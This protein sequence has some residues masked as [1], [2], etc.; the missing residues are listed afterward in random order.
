MKV[1]IVDDGHY[2]V[3]YLKHLLDWKI[4][5]VDLVMTTTNPI[6][7]KEILRQSA[8]DILITDIRMPEVS[9]IDLLEYV[10]AMRLKAKVIFLSGYSDFEY[11]QKAIRLGAFDYL[12]K[13]VDKEDM[14]KVVRSVIKTIK[15]SRTETSAFWD[16]ANGLSY[17]VSAISGNDSLAP[18]HT[19]Q[20]N[21]EQERMCF[22]KCTLIDEE[23]ATNLKDKLKDLDALIWL[24]P[25]LAF[26]VASESTAERIKDAFSAILLSEPFQLHKKQLVRQIFYLF[27]YNEEVKPADF[28]ILQNAEEFSNLE[29]R[30]WESAR[31]K[32][33]KRFP[34]LI[35]RKHKII[36]LL[37]VAYYLYF[38]TD[39][40]PTKQFLDWLIKRIENPVE[41]YES[42]VFT[43]SRLSQG[44]ELPIEDIV[45]TIRTYISGHLDEALSL[46]EL[47]QIVHLHP[48]YL[49]KFYKQTTGENLSAHITLKRMERAAK[50]LVE[51]N[52]HVVDIARMVGYKKAQYFIKLFKEQ[53]RVTPQVYRQ[54]NSDS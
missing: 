13:P 11:A 45:D 28:H 16:S 38:A 9:G 34:Q 1:L 41:V 54:N 20:C 50:L 17:L 39:R 27:L 46:E 52:L 4:Y 48:V 40:V 43:I 44:E 3:E 2:I 53:Y 7:A 30:K 36:Y 21:Y 14:E 22:F 42:V 49:S 32:I 12:L 10:V 24:F 18:V 51:S 26:G 19:P 23:D 35:S 33:Q 8:I 29:S 25:S 31:Q 15:D 6:E 5:G 37:E 47:G